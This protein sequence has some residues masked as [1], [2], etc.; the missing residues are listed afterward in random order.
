MRIAGYILLAILFLLWGRRWIRK[1]REKALAEQQRRLLIAQGKLVEEPPIPRRKRRWRWLRRSKYLLPELPRAKELEIYQELPKWVEELLQA[2][3]AMRAAWQAQNAAQ[4]HYETCKTTAAVPLKVDAN[5][6]SLLSKYEAV[7]I[8]EWRSLEEVRKAEQLF[9]SAWQTTFQKRKALGEWLDTLQPYDLEDLDNQGLLHIELARAVNDESA[10]S[11]F[12][13]C[14][15]PAATEGAL[16]D[17]KVEEALSEQR[18]AVAKACDQLLELTRLHTVAEH[19]YSA[20]NTVTEAAITQPEKPNEEEVRK[21]IGAAEQWAAS[22]QAAHQEVMTQFATAQQ[23]LDICQLSIAKAR[24]HQANLESLLKAKLETTQALTTHSRN[25]S[26]ELTKVRDTSPPNHPAM[27]LTGEQAARHHTARRLLEVAAHLHESTRKPLATR[28][29]TLT[30]LPAYTSV[31]TEAEQVA[32]VAVRS[33]MRKLGFALAQRRALASKIDA[34]KRE[35]GIVTSDEPTLDSVNAEAF[36]R[37]HR[38]WCASLKRKQEDI[39]DRKQRLEAYNVQ[40][41]ERNE[42]VKQTVLA[43]RT[44]PAMA[45]LAKADATP[46]P[47]E[48]HTL[49]LAASKL[50][51]IT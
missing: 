8:R 40:M 11:S 50:A 10:L 48:L 25:P 7:A 23:Q 15:L 4:K 45:S 44:L 28:L 33:A 36:V 29:A 42:Q 6:D 41:A 1:E 20:W 46:M 43:I 2:Y 38:A 32:M 30:P 35:S 24:E 31:A 51:A 49:L 26:A 5:G 13:K 3:H 14:H 37:S 34:A 39:D 12:T 21:Y 19:A 22:V 18:I 16:P 17:A 27:R 47:V 9:V